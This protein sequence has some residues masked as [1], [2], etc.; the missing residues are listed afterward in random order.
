MLLKQKVLEQLRTKEDGLTAAQITHLINESYPKDSKYRY[1]HGS[2][3]TILNRFVQQK[4][5]RISEDKKGERGGNV[6]VLILDGHFC[7]RC[8]H[9][10]ETKST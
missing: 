7:P 10:L 4:V 8:G 2:V 5:A 9:S 3:S 1:N 6:Y